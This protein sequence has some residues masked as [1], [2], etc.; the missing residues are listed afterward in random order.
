[1]HFCPTKCDFLFVH[2]GDGRRWFIPS[3]AVQGGSH[4]V[5]GGPKYGRFEIDADLPL[6][7]IAQR[8]IGT[9]ADPRRGSGAVKRDAL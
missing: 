7:D 5:L 6:V 8:W 3:G 2:V 1:M 9:L 4:I